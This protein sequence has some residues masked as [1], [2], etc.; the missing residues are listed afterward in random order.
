MNVVFVNQVLFAHRTRLPKQSTI[1]TSASVGRVN[2]EFDAQLIRTADRLRVMSAAQLNQGDRVD[3]ARKLIV[4]MALHVRPGIIVPTLAA[5]ALGDQLAVVGKEYAA[6]AASDEAED[7]A[8]QLR[9]LRLS[10]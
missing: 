9:E 1:R 10:L 6:V 7:M 4:A 3:S 8:N 2:E 5:S